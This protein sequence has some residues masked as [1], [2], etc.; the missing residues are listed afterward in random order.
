MEIL[1]K[2]QP[3]FVFCFLPQQTAGLCELRDKAG[4]DDIQVNVPLLRSQLRGFEILDALRLHRQ[5]EDMLGSWFNFK[6]EGC[7]ADLMFV[8]LQVG[9]R[10]L[11]SIPFASQQVSVCGLW[12]IVMCV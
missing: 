4:N 5:G 11:R 6:P 12:S 1:R 2:T 8:V 7:V 10:L 3:H 9:G